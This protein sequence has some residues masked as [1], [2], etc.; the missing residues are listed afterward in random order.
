M[1]RET[2]EPFDEGKFAAIEGKPPSSNP[3]PDGS[4]EHVQWRK[5]YEFVEMHDEDGEIPCDC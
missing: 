3:Y 2:T 1:M 4:S 5:G